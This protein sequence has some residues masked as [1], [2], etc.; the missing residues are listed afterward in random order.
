MSIFM[1]QTELLPESILVITILLII[2]FLTP[3]TEPVYAQFKRFRSTWNSNKPIHKVIEDAYHEVSRES[4]VNGQE[5]FVVTWWAKDY[6]ILPSKYLRDIKSGGWTRLSFYQ[7]IS[8]AFHLHCSVGDLYYALNAQNMPAIVQKGLNPRLAQITPVVVEEIDFAFESILESHS[9]WQEVTAMPLFSEIAHRIAARFLIGK[10]LCRDELFIKR[11]MSMLQS[12][13]VTALVTA[14]LPL[15]RCRSFFAHPISL[16]HQW[17]LWQ[18]TN[19]LLPVIES[20]IEEV[21]RTSTG[22][23]VDAI[24][25]TLDLIPET[26]RSV[27]HRRFAHELLHN[28]WAGSAAPGGMITEVLYQLL[29]HQENFVAIKEEI[30]NSHAEHG[31]SEGMINALSLLDSFIRETNRLL[32][33][34]SVTA[35]RTVLEQPFQFSDGLTLPVGTRF[36]FPAKAIQG[37]CTELADPK[38][39][40]GR[41]FLTLKTSEP[42]G[43]ASPDQ[44]RWGASSV[45]FSNLAWGY[46]N[47]VCPGRFFAVRMVKLVISNLILHYEVMWDRDVD[48][49]P[50]RVNI[51]GQF[52][53]N[54]S[55]TVLLRRRKRD[56]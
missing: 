39:F 17:R 28:L 5:P 42:S 20:R 34:G 41:R 10:E 40:D 49:S 4:L 26:L 8:D 56:E 13:F 43:T 27:N 12:L 44:K 7:N 19:M 14:K 29:I 31:W 25:W 53:P 23:Q 36:G 22:S 51:E 54:M 45:D 48:I 38:T 18:C 16:F 50:P 2:F 37:S 3:N 24:Q 1:I 55:Q 52:V 47:H 6:L 33:T 30:E 9:E 15:G 35:A 32:P 11:S 21:Q 46:G